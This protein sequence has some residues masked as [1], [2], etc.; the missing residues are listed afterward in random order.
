MPK[1]A[2]CLPIA[3]ETQL[4]T[5]VFFISIQYGKVRYIYIDLLCG[6]PDKED[7]HRGYAIHVYIYFIYTY[8]QVDIHIYSQI[9]MDTWLPRLSDLWI[10]N[11]LSN[12]ILITHTTIINRYSIM[13]YT[14]ACRP[15][16]KSRASFWQGSCRSHDLQGWKS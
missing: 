3:R 1:L 5:H 6:L 9:R 13:I 7:L 12:I 2:S 15:D 4:C 14:C 8:I 10:Y 16:Q 11:L